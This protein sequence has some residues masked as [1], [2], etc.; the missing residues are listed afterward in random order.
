MK[1]R[2]QMILDDMH[3][4]SIIAIVF[5]FTIVLTGIINHLIS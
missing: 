2:F 1:Q 5:L 3:P 4:L